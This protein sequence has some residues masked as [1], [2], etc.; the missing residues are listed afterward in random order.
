MSLTLKRFIKG[1]DCNFV[2]VATFPKRSADKRQQ[3]IWGC[4]VNQGTTVSWPLAHTTMYCGKGGEHMAYSSAT[5]HAQQKEEASPDDCEFLVIHQALVLTYLSCQR[6]KRKHQRGSLGTL[7]L[8]IQIIFL[9]PRFLLNKIDGKILR[10]VVSIYKSSIC[11]ILNSL[12][13]LC[14]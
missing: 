11:M 1:S 9:N 5:A 8:Y 7:Y 13:D 14:V 6:K 4:L 10:A 12:I 3:I 2:C